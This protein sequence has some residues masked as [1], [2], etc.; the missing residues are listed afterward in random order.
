MT[1]RSGAG[2]RVGIVVGSDS[3]LEIMQQAGRV[4]Q[5]FG[6]PYELTIASAHRSPSRA[7]A[8]ALA[9]EG[10]GIQVLIAAA[11]AAAHLAGVL[12]SRSVLPVIGVPLGGSALN[13]LDALLSTAQ[14]PGGVPVATVAIGGAR[15]AALLAVQILSTADPALRHRYRAYKDRLAHEVEEKAARLTPKGDVGMV[16]P[17]GRAR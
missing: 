15:N 1:G 16:P 11:G 14:M 9:A 6:V 5:E 4:L 2:P 17:P 12:A 8:Y 7:D 3:D 13:G 10:R